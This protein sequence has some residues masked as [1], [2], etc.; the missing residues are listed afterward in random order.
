MKRFK[1]TLLTGRSLK[2]G[3][4]KE[5]SK[6]SDK[7]KESVSICEVHPKDMEDTGLNEGD[8]INVTT[9]FGSVIVKC[10]SSDHIPKPGIIFIPYGP[11][12]SA[13]MGMNTNSTGMP[14]YKGISAEVEPA[15]GE[16]VL[17]IRQL[18]TNLGR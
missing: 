6:T 5:I 11:Y 18:L 15:P 2:Q 10:V 13:I 1:A 14:T 17:D 4:G 16:R 9:Q 12:A 3:M 7:Y 8:A